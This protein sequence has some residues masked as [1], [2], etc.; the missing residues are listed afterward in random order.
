MTLIITENETIE[1]Q[2]GTLYQLEITQTAAPVVE[3]TSPGPQ[4]QDGD[5][6][7]G[8][9]DA[10][11]AL[12]SVWSS[13]KINAELTAAIANLVDSAPGALDTLNELA[14]AIQNNDADITGILTALTNRVRTD[15]ASQGLDA[16]AQSNARSNISAVSTTDV[17]TTSHDF[18]AD[19]EG[20]LS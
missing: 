1:L 11:T 12:D 16:T 3:M 17:G 9:D 2:S 13:S 4:G 5:S 19:F 18:V 8:I 20:G 10:S 6:G 7:A 14:T 15:T